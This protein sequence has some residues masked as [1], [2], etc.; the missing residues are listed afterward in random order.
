[1]SFL[2]H[3][4]VATNGMRFSSSF[5]LCIAS[6]NV[7]YGNILKLVLAFPTEGTKPCLQVIAAGLAEPVRVSA[8]T[9]AGSFGRV[10]TEPGSDPKYAPAMQ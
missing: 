6:L 4:M 2:E 10:G 9:R 3:T 8:I 7:R 5:Q 1:M